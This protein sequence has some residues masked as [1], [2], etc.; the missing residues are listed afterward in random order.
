VAQFLQDSTAE[1]S[2]VVRVVGEVDL[3]VTE[4][5]KAVV[6]RCLTPGATV[7]LDL[8]DLAFIDSSGLGT[9]VQL[10]KEAA[11]QDTALTLTNAG[12]H[13]R[14]VFEVTGLTA[15]FDARPSDR[16]AH[17]AADV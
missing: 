9:L 1:G 10:L 3:S 7:E 5:L 13:I 14:R 6:R 17:G 11:R 8:S 15:V 12:P 2:T 4:D 16:D